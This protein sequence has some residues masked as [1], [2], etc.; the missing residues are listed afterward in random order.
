MAAINREVAAS[1][2]G[3]SWI[4]RMFEEGERLRAQY[5]DENVFDFSLGNPHLPPPREF[6]AALRRLAENPPPGVHRYMPNPGFPEVRRKVAEWY[7]RR[8]RTPIPPEHVVMTCGAAG[9]I[10]VALRTLLDPGDE[11][12]LFSPIFAEYRFY[13]LH[14]QGR[15]GYVETDASFLIDPERTAEA[16]TERTRVVLINSP[17]NPTGRVYPESTIV[18]LCRLLADKSRRYGRPIVLLTDEP[19]R[20][21]VYDGV[22]APPVMPHYPATIAASSFSKELGLA[23]ERI[24]YLIVHPDFPDAGETLRGLIFCLRTMGFVNAPALMQLAA[25]ESLDSSVDVEAYRANRDLLHGALTG[26]G[27]AME[28]PEGAFYLFPRTPIADDVEFVRRL[29]AERILAV[30]GSGFG[31]AGH[32]RLSYAVDR[33]VIE[34]SLPQFERV[35]RGILSSGA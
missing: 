26:M 7:G 19:Y 33:G 12:I 32:V 31:R 9:A 20:R 13:V 1:L 5:G 8:E 14:A 3:A 2:E 6:A 27:W 24:G 11:V 16:I 25:A 17:N 35:L 21:L 28:K 22:E 23:G 10:N 4:R 29:Q 18:E 15:G 34:R 30:P